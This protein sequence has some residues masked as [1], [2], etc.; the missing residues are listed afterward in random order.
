MMLTRVAWL[1]VAVWL[2]SILF[3][4]ELLQRGV[5]TSYILSAVFLA[6]SVGMGIYLGYKWQVLTKTERWGDNSQSAYMAASGLSIL[7]INC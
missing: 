4:W 2:L 6:A 5:N 1:L 3:G 7:S